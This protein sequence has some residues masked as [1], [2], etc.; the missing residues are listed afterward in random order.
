MQSLHRENTMDFPLLVFTDLD[1]TLLD[2]HSY[3][4][5]GAV[6]ALQ[7]LHQHSIPIVL[8]SS[9]TRTELQKLQQRL[10]L[11]EPFIAENGGGIFI[12]AGYTKLDTRALEKLGDYYFKPLGRS[13]LTIRK[14]FEPLRSKYNIKG[15]GDMTVE[16][17]IAATG[18]DR[19]EA[20]MAGQRDFTEPFLFLSEPLLQKLKEEVAGHGLKI[21]RGGRFYHLMAAGQDKGFAVTETLSLFQRVCRNRII[22]VGLGDS[23]NDFL[24]LKTVDIPVLIAKPDG[25]YENLDLPGLSKAPFPGSKGWGTAI[26]TILDGCQSEIR[27]DMSKNY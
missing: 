13:Y 5:D 14:I 21:V 10:G 12:P 24:M 1:G 11:N 19:E 27:S 3:S 8:T 23:E 22:T 9:K 18:L 16:E 17:I 15:F 4:F 2:H 20:I 7:R 26:M 6:T 25:S